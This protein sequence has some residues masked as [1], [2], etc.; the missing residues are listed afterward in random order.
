MNRILLSLTA[1]TVSLT[2]TA[3]AQSGQIT[4]WMKKQLSDDQNTMIQQRA[5]EF[6]KQNNV[7]VNVELIAYENFFPKWSAAIESGNVPDVS[8]FGYQEIGQFYAQGVLRDVSPLV[9]SIQKTNGLMQN[10]LQKPVTFNGGQYGVPFWGE[11]QV[12]YYRKDLLAKAGF[13]VPPRTWAE[14]RTMAKKLTGGGVYGAGLGFG[15]G[16][17]DAEFLTRAILWSYGGSLNPAAQITATPNV[18]ATNLLRDLFVTDKSTPPS[19]LGWDD[20]GNNKA[21]LS[22]QAAMVFNSGSIVN[23][24]KNDYPDLYANTGIAALPSGPKGNAIPGISNY[25]GIFKAS[26]NVPLAEKFISYLTEKNWYGDW[27]KRG[28]PINI[29][30]YTSLASDP[31]WQTPYTKPFIDSVK[32]FKFLG[33]PQ[34]YKPADGEI[35]NLRL[36]NDAFQSMMSGSSSVADGLSTLQKKVQDA[37]K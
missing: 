17:S 10:S 7:K 21:Y 12:L 36:V 11:A 8:F 14:F 18:Q 9:K 13:K 26:K 33:Y 15:K 28:A 1:L 29:P 31:V 22:G 4:F 19:A 2:A 32:S 6:G 16:N 27:I 34:V 23:V 3:H 37:N 24:L 35:Y 20:S 5:L 25:L 30:V